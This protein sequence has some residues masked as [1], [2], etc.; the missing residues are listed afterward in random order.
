MIYKKILIA[1]DSSECSMRAAKKGLALAHQVNAVAGLIFVIDIT[2]AMGN[3]DAGTTRND[4]EL[5]LKKEAEQTL[6]QLAAMYNGNELR[7]FMPEGHPV[8]EIIET[9]RVWDADL[10]VMGTHGY[11]GLRHLFM[12]S[13]AEEVIRHAHLPVMVVPPKS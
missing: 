1:V 13:T 4:A 5:I 11:K 6:D 3:P 9:A 7:K 2:K 10:I 12:G 8:K